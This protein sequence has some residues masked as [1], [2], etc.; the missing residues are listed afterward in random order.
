M[1]PQ[2]EPFFLARLP[3]FCMP[4]WSRWHRSLERGHVAAYIYYCTVRIVLWRDLHCVKIPQGEQINP[5]IT[6]LIYVPKVEY[7]PLQSIPSLSGVR[8]KYISPSQLCFLFL[9]ATVPRNQFMGSL[10]V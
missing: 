9:L 2:L 10:K 3:V 1:T 7:Y 4:N 6:G 5:G 8:I